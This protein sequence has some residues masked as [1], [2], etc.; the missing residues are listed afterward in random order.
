MLEQPNAMGLSYAERNRLGIS[1][2][3]NLPRESG[4]MS[5]AAKVFLDHHYAKHMPENLSEG[6]DLSDD[7]QEEA[8]DK[9]D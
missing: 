1:R 7:E 4:G 2:K 6:Q 8:E 3:R 9:P 5:P